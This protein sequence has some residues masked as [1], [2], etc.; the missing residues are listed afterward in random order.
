M[1]PYHTRF[2]TTNLLRPRT[3]FLSAD[4]THIVPRT[5][6]PSLFGSTLSSDP[7]FVLPLTPELVPGIQVQ[8]RVITGSWFSWFD[9][10]LI[11][12]GTRGFRTKP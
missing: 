10:R 5:L 2:R 11:R 7:V 12:R 6:L 9:S 3:T 8:V 1:N 4:K